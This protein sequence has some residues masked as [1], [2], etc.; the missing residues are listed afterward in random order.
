[1]NKTKRGKYLQAGHMSSFELV[2]ITQQG[3]P[4]SMSCRCSVRK[5]D[6]RHVTRG[7]LTVSILS[8]FRVQSL[9]GFSIEES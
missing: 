1:M 8:Y 2:L 6:L 9:S 4:P 5:Q 3:F 7:L